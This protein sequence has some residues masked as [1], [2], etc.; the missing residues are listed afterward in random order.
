MTHHPPH[1]TRPR[2]MPVPSLLLIVSIVLAVAGVMSLLGGATG[3]GPET[4]T[5]PAPGFP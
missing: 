4:M 1:P 2:D 5:V 3:A